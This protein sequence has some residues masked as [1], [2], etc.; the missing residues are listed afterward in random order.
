MKIPAFSP[1]VGHQVCIFGQLLAE[2]YLSN[3]LKK[4]KNKKNVTMQYENDSKIKGAWFSWGKVDLLGIF[5]L[6][7]AR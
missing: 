3:K 5:Q 4:N 2:G 1:S 7:K 6:S